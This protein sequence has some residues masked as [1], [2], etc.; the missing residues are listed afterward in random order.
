MKDNEITDLYLDLRL[1]YTKLVEV[2][3]KLS[4]AAQI[5]GGTAGPDKFLMEAIDEAEKVLQT[6]KEQI[7]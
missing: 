6:H 7:P 1:R 5:T 4:F 3:K 2:L